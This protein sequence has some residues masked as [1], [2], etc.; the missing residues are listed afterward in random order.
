MIKKLTIILIILISIIL[1]G[2]FVIPEPPEPPEPGP[3]KPVY[4]ALLV[5]VSRGLK[6]PPYNVARMEE[7]LGNCR[8]GDDEKEFTTINKLID[9]E[10]TKEAIFNNIVS[11]FT[12]A[13]ENDVS[14]FYWNG[15]GGAKIE[16]HINPND[17]N[18]D[19]ET[20]ISVHELERYLSA[21]PGTKV[22]I[23]DTC[24]SGGFIGKGFKDLL[25]SDDFQVIT[26]CRKSEVSYSIDWVPE[27]YTHFTMGIYLACKKLSAD[28][29]K[30]GIINLKELWESVR[31]Y[32]FLCSGT[33]YHPTQSKFPIVEY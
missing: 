4:R 15:H 19:P 26:S 29:D 3:N 32:H 13:D 23:M 25:I 30:D 12:G 16:P 21:I 7:I 2:C 11:T 27:P 8:F 9:S 20:W 33:Q 14:Y 28:K 17:Y 10:G 1:S 5:G 24:Y 18:G 31:N 22:V 6:S